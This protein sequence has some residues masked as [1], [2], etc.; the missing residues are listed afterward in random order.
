[1]R[2]FTCLVTDDRYSVPQL[3]F[4]LVADEARARELARRELLRSEH[5]R[6]VELHDGA[7]LVYN[8]RRPPAPAK[9]VPGGQRESSSTS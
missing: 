8:E 7:R 5:H 2:T 6:A 3:S 1:M 4:L 9:D